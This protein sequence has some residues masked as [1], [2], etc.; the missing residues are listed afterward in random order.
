[1]MKEHA[2]LESCSVLDN[3]YDVKLAR[4]DYYLSKQDRIMFYLLAQRSRHEMLQM[5]LEAEEKHIV[6]IQHIFEA[7]QRE[8]NIFLK[9]NEAR[10]EEY[11]RLSKYSSTYEKESAILIESNDVLL[12]SIHELANLNSQK[13]AKDET[14]YLTST[15]LLQEVENLLTRLK[16]NQDQ[17]RQ[18]EQSCENHFAEIETKFKFLERAVFA[19]SQSKPNVIPLEIEEQLNELE[20]ESLKLETELAILSEQRERRLADVESKH[21]IQFERKQLIKMV[22]NLE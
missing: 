4:Q 15:K 8:L 19:K 10:F 6:H 17:I 16:A 14:I 7:I 12:N 3:A 22:Q 1:M 18:I 5:G 11:K 20:K 9:E 21:L 13:T 2:E